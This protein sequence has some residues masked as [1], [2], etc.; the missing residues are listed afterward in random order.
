M[1]MSK[2]SKDFEDA[3]VDEFYLLTDDEGQSKEIRSFNK[4]MMNSLKPKLTTFLKKDAT[5][6]GQLATLEKVK[7]WRDIVTSK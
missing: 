2:S 1:N 3:T 7:S 5:H 4:D 6:S